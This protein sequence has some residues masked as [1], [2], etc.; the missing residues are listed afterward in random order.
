MDSSQYVA[1]IEKLEKLCLI[2]KSAYR[3]AEDSNDAANAKKILERHNKLKSELKN[4]IASYK[5]TLEQSLSN[6]TKEAVASN[7]FS[8]SPWFDGNRPGFVFRDGI[9]GK[10]YYIDDDT[11]MDGKNNTLLKEAQ[12][13]WKKDREKEKEQAESTTSVTTTTTA[14]GTKTTTTIT[15]KTPRRTVRVRSKSKEQKK[16][17]TL[18]DMAVGVNAEDTDVQLTAMV[19]LRQC[20]SRQ[21]IGDG[22]LTVDVERIISLNLVPRLIYLLEHGTHPKLVYETCWVLT[23]IC[24]ETFPQTKTVVDAGVIPVLVSKFRSADHELKGQLAWLVGNI[25]AECVHFRKQFVEVG[26]VPLLTD[27]INISNEKK[28]FG[29][30]M[31]TGKQRLIVLNGSYCKYT[32]TLTAG[33]SFLRCSLL[34]LF[35]FFF[36]SSCFV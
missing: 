22:S 4:L 9:K 34:L 32:S 5:S 13:M 24:K 16:E 19:K 26:I 15:T 1:K 31:Q 10:G 23:N 27:F 33:F 18:E 8:P 2:T 36:F 21:D 12:D 28:L 29:E 3:A 11:L 30:P 25:S 7:L 17:W 6:L 20:I 35:F 14:A